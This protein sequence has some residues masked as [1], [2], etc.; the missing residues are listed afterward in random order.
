MDSYISDPCESDSIIPVDGENG[1]NTDCEL[2]DSESQPSPDTNSPENPEQASLDFPRSLTTQ[3]S[4]ESL[5]RW[6][7][8]MITWLSC[9]PNFVPFFNNCTWTRKGKRHP[10]CGLCDDPPPGRP[11]EIKILA[12]NAMLCRISRHCPVITPRSICDYS[13]S[14]DNV[15]HLVYAHFNCTP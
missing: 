10:N 3:E 12:L 11:A 5:D 9:D 2:S 4:Q 1:A 7:S 6:K 13:T 15:W 8:D 14:L